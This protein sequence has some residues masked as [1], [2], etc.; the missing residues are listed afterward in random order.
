MIT[1]LL[2]ENIIL[3]RVNLTKNLIFKIFMLI[4]HQYNGTYSEF[5]DSQYFELA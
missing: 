2:V 1:R 3:E 4:H 5:S